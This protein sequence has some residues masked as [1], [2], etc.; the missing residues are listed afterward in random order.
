MTYGIWNSETWLAH[1]IQLILWLKLSFLLYFS[2]S[3]C[4]LTLA[5]NKYYILSYPFYYI[6][7][8]LYF[9]L[10]FLDRFFLVFFVVS[11][12]IDRPW[13]NLAKQ[14]C[15]QRTRKNWFKILPWSIV[16]FNSISS[17]IYILQFIFIHMFAQICIL[18]IFFIFNSKIPLRH[19]LLIYFSFCEF[20]FLLFSISSLPVC[21]TRN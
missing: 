11:T 15:S 16:H 21:I 20:W 17:F 1:G 18:T 9:Y 4:L 10:V 3:F 19:L 12:G 5:M 14:S 7:S 8:V 2:I 6:E 13:E